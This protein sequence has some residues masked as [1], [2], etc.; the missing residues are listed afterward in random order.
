MT[1]Y[2]DAA[3]VAASI[4]PTVPV[5]TVHHA[6]R[7]GALASTKVGRR[8]LHTQ[9]QVDAWLASQSTT[10]ELLT[11]RSRRSLGRSA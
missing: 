6:R 2:M 4:H 10:A 5:S 11:A 7:T 8:H 9:E 1:P 3:E